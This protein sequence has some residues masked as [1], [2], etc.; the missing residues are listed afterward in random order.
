MAIDSAETGLQ[1]QARSGDVVELIAPAHDDLPAVLA[2]I[3]G[4][5]TLAGHLSVLSK[6]LPFE[7]SAIRRRASLVIRGISAQSGE[8]GRFLRTHIAQD[9]SRVQVV[10]LLSLASRIAEKSGIPF[11]G[12]TLSTDMTS[13]TAD[14]IWA[15]DVALAVSG[16]RELVVVDAR[17]VHHPEKLLPVTVEQLAKEAL[18]V[19]GLSEQVAVSGRTVVTAQLASPEEVTA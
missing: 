18:L 11:T 5:G 8:L 14:Q 16:N 1:L 7:S 10:D 13:M 9:G 17:H 15:V 6:P 3:S 2:A 12:V 19:I 4:R